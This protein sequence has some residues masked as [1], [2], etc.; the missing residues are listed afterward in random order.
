MRT[1]KI[2]YFLIWTWLFLVCFTMAAVAQPSREYKVKAVFL[3]NFAQ[4]VQWHA[5][6]FLSAQSPLVI[7]ILGEDPFNSYLDETVSGE[8][9]NGHPIV[10]QRFNSAYE[11]K[12]CHILFIHSTE[13]YRM[14]DILAKLKDK[15]ILTVSDSKTF[16]NDGGMIRFLTE[17]NKIRLVINLDEVKEAGLDI[18]SK[19]LRLAEIYDSAKK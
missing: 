14:K 5:Q 10:V 4:F 7:G 6:N 2:K 3:F 8:S 11:V 9:I 19:L 15:K 17:N 13:T 16:M 1:K 12:N 18:S